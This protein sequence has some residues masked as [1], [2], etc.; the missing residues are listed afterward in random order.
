MLSV[1]SILTVLWKEKRFGATVVLLTQLAL[2]TYGFYVLQR[3]MGTVEDGWLVLAAPALFAAGALWVTAPRESNRERGIERWLPI[4]LRHSFVILGVLALLHFSA[5]G[6]TL[7]SPVVETSRFDLGGSGGAGFPSRAVLFGIPTLALLS[8]ATLTHETRRI[9]LFIWVLFTAS[10]VAMGFKGALIEVLAIG[11]IGYFINV[12]NPRRRVLAL[13]ALGFLGA[14]LYVQFVGAKYGTLSGSGNGLA[15]IV[16]RSTTQAIQG[17][18]SALNI[19]RTMP[20]GSVFAQDMHVLLARY[21]GSKNA[22]DYPFDSLI[23]S[24]ITGT[25]LRQ[26]LF[27]VP[28]TVGGTVYLIFSVAVPVVVLILVLLGFIWSKLLRVIRFPKNVFAASAAAVLLYGIRVFLMNGGGAYLV[29]N[30]AFTFVMLCLCSL[31][32]F[33]MSALARRRSGVDRSQIPAK[34]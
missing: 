30:L 24:L 22:T 17:G 19:R 33:F 3:E 18:Y 27:I 26:G 21:T 16:D 9:T 11:A 2:P 4:F 34:A 31:P 14:L 29:I 25:P 23:S 6:I 8:I 20:E 15:Y 32:S 12:G 5:V 7:F 1:I 10:Q 13:F 28:V